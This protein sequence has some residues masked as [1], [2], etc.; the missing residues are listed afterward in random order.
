MCPWLP[1]AGQGAIAIQIRVGDDK[2]RELFAPLGHAPTMIDT[3]AE[4]AFLAAL[5][6]GCQ[7]PIGAAVLRAASAA[8]LHGFIADVR[9]SA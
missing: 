7:V 5:E 8:T 4:R 6:G 9:A 1:A 3:T 2:S